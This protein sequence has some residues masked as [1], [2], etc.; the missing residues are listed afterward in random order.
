[1]TRLG[2]QRLQLS[3]PR[4]DLEIPFKLLDGSVWGHSVLPATSPRTRT[5]PPKLVGFHSKS[6]Y[7]HL[8]PNRVFQRTP[9]PPPESES[10][11]LVPAKTPPNFLSPGFSARFST[12]PE[13]TAPAARVARQSRS[14]RPRTVFLRLRRGAVIS[15]VPRRRHKDPASAAELWMPNARVQTWRSPA[16]GGWERGLRERASNIGCSP[17]QS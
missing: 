4:M 12:P 10:P 7:D 14:P 17:K 5:D 6:P 9:D 11:L 13:P 3:R 16:P 15:S 2:S 8:S 1:M